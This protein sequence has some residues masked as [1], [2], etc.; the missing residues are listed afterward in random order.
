MSP[1]RRVELGILP[2]SVE[3]KRAYKFR[4]YPMKVQQAELSEWERQLRRLYNLAHEQR[5]AAL[6]RYRD[7]DFQKGA[8]PSCRVAVPGVHTAACDHVDYFRQAREMTQLLEVDAQLSRVI[9]CARQEVLRDLDKAWQRWRK[10]LGGRPRFK[11]RTDSCR[12]YLSTPKHWEI[13]G[14]YLRLS[15]LA[16]SVGEIRIEQD[17]AF[18]E[19]ALLS[20]CSIVR[21]VDEW[22]ACLPLTFTQ[23]IERAPHRSV[24]LNRGVVHALADSDG[25]VVDSPKFFERALATVQKRSR[26]L[27]RKVSGSRNAHKARIKLAKAH[28]RVRRQRAAFLH[29]E[30]AYYSK[31]FDLVALEDMSVRKMTATAGEAPEMGRGAQ[32]DLNRGILDVGWYELA[33]QIDYK[34]LAHGGELLR[35]DPGQTTPLACVTEEQPAR[36]IS[37]ACAVCGIPLA[38]PA[39]GNARMRCTACGSSQ[40]GDVNAAE[41]V[42]TR[43]LSSA[44]SGPKSPKA[45]IKIKGRQKR[46]GTPAN[47]AGEASGG[48]PPVRGPVEGGTLAYVVEP[49][50]ESQSDT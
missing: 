15:G 43:A 7:W 12:I 11:R 27:A 21:D 30:S 35:V 17:R 48:D 38:R 36:G 4:L 18:P 6:L 33:R 34:R 10:K 44:P 5:L 13:A 40:V 46:L 41:N 37:S 14:R 45:S 25:R 24:G 20:S 3:L 32:R 2:G 49:V 31:G 26:D 28:Q 47:R 50:S 42:L 29:Q 16:S 19:G 1:E 8:C 22:Y 9:C 39:S 23:P